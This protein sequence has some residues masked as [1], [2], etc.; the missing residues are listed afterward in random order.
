M[1]FL[2]AGMALCLQ[3]FAPAYALAVQDDKMARVAGDAMLWHMQNGRA[4]QAFEM[5]P[6]GGDIHTHLRGAIYAESWLEWAAEDGLCADMSRSALV[7][8][9]EATCEESGWV[10]AATAQADDGM[11]LELINALSTRNYVPS[12]GWSGHNQFFATFG[13]ISA[14]PERLGDQLAAVAE[15]AGNQNILY[16]E[17]METLVLPELF[18]LIAGVKMSGNISDDYQTLM[19]GKLGAALDEL[20]EKIQLQLDIAKQKKADLLRCNS[21]TSA[22][23]CDVEIRFLHQ[24][25]REFEPAMVYAQIVLGWAVM[26]NIPEVVGLNLVAP[27]DGFRALRDY[28][29][30][31]RML[32]HLYTERGPQNITLHAGELAMGLVRP[33]QLKFHIREAIEVGHAKRIGHGVAIKYEENSDQLLSKMVEDDILVEINLTSNAVILGVEGQAHPLVLYRDQDVPY[34]VSTDDEGV[35]RI[36]LTHEYIRLAQTFDVP[37]FELREVSRN[38]LT[39]SFLDG[40]SLWNSPDCAADVNAVRPAGAACQQLLKA[41]DKAR[42]QWKLEQKFREFENM[43]K[44]P[45]RKRNSFN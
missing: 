13:R 39:Y 24:V 7:F 29:L 32:D 8:R 41:S 3:A 33:K 45:E 5:M 2:I 17:L 34:T 14:M 1:R 27:E 9:E 37:Y 30:H 43:L 19:S 4:R 12:N 25:I 20:T 11:R 36:D 6:K 10:D 16:L 31:M 15:R 23:G 35:S 22:A 28:S 42:L 44:I 40:D 21:A 38:S 26:E 18:P